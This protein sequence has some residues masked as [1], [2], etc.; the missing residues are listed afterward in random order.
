MHPEV[1][2]VNLL[3]DSQS[4]G[5]TMKINHHTREDCLSHVVRGKTGRGKVTKAGEGGK[6]SCPTL[7]EKTTAAGEQ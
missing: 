4:T 6:G 7:E 3:G 1:C 2:F 5:L